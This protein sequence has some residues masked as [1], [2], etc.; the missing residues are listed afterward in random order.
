MTSLW[1]SK[2]LHVKFWKKV[3]IICHF[4]SFFE[5]SIQTKFKVYSL[6][7]SLDTTILT[8]QKFDLS[9]LR[10]DLGLGDLS[11]C[12]V[13]ALNWNFAYVVRNTLIKSQKLLNFS[14]NKILSPP[15]LIGC[16]K[17]WN[18]KNWFT[19]KFN[20]ARDGGFT[21]RWD[22]ADISVQNFW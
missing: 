8:L 1:L 12:L 11:Q 20:S 6:H 7:I 3:D 19:Y 5:R 21:V 22:I 14:N 2:W 9:F 13:K 16:N 18:V 15:G 4:C 10:G 17:I